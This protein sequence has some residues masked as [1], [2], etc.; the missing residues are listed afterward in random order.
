MNTA[1]YAE[2]VATRQRTTERA[3]AAAGFDAVVIQSGSPFTYFVD[4]MDAPFHP[5]PHFAHWTPLEG[6]LHLLFVRPGKKPRLVRVAPEDYWY[7][8]SPLGSPFWGSGLFLEGAALVL[9]FVFQAVG[10]HRLEARASIVN[11]RGNGALRKL[12]A[13]QEGV[14]RRSF[15]RNGEYHDQVLWSVLKEEWFAQQGEPV[16]L[17]H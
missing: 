6:P 15:L 7:E 9:D 10:V 3:L 14:L 5:T 17:V 16:V 8:Q 4:D 1:A 2:H 13:V 11:G 12:G